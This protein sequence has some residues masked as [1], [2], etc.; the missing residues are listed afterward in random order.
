MGR[1]RWLRG[2]GSLFATGRRFIGY[3]EYLFG[4]QG[5]K[6]PSAS[7]VFSFFGK[8]LKAKK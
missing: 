3:R 8:E 7:R 1:V 2:L 6:E 4:A 5:G